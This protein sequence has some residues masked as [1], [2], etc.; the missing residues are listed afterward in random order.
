[1]SEQDRGLLGAIALIV[2]GIII[3][4]AL[5]IGASFYLEY[6]G[7]PT[8]TSICHDSLGS[9]W[10]PVDVETD[11][12]NETV[13]ITCERV[14]P[15]RTERRVVETDLNVFDDIEEADS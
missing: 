14:F 5:L 10:H 1:M 3:G 8:P 15:D 7:A 13:E 9:E 12:P 6:R 4:V 11:R 2:I